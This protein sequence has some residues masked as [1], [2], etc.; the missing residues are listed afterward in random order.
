MKP[1]VLLC[2]ALLLSVYVLSVDS[3]AVTDS[4]GALMSETPEQEALATPAEAD[5]KKFGETCTREYD[6]V[7]GSDGND[8]S[9][10]CVLCEENR[11]EKKNVKMVKKGK[12]SP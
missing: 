2:F 7:C 12:C 3:E 11:R 6:P 5:C 10:E 4:D 8:Y 1:I 9:T